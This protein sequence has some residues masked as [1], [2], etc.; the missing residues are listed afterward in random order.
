MRRRVHS[1][2]RYVKILF[3]LGNYVCSYEMGS[4]NAND[5]LI[6]IYL[7]RLEVTSK[8]NCFIIIVV[9][10]LCRVGN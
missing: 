1:T 6:Q 2:M 5:L 10:V 9:M 3:F 8:Y 7:K 4:K